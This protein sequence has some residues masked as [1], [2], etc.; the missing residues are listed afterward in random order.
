MLQSM[1]SQRVRCNLETEQQLS[2]DLN[3]AL[4]SKPM[5]SNIKLPLISY[6]YLYMCKLYP[7][8]TG[9]LE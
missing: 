4:I 7:N 6:K 9:L 3:P 8:L 2:Y 5:I 1:G